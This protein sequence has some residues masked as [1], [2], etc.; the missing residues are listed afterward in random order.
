[1][2]R[3]RWGGAGACPCWFCADGGGGSFPTWVQE[4][5]GYVLKIMGGQDK[6][7][8]PMK[9]GVLT[10]NRVQAS[11]AKTPLRAAARVPCSLRTT[12]PGS[13]GCAAAAAQRALG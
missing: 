7:G 13:A 9:Q 2:R 8:F 3:R 1:M 6:Q 11:D 4:F 5:K 12:Q 10:N